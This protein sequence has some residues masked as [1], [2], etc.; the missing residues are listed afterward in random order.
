MVKVDNPQ[1]TKDTKMKFFAGRCYWRLGSSKTSPSY[2]SYVTKSLKDTV[3]KVYNVSASPAQQNSSNVTNSSN[4]STSSPANS[5]TSSPA[6]ASPTTPSPVAMECN[7]SL[8]NLQSP[9]DIN[10][11]EASY[12]ESS[13]L[14]YTYSK[15]DELSLLLIKNTGSVI[16]IEG[17]GLDQDYVTFNGTNYSLKSIE[18]HHG[19]EHRINDVEYPLEA[20]LVHEDAAGNL[21]I[22]AVLFQNGQR[23]ALLE[24]HF[25][26]LDLPK[27]VGNEKSIRPFNLASM[28]GLNNVATEYWS[29]DGTTTSTP[30][31]SAHWLV[32]RH[33]PVISENQIEAFPLKNNS[34]AI[35]ATN[36]R[37]I[38]TNTQ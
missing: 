21:L 3:K 7:T 13:L 30:C 18:F 24:D 2:I 31:T 6:T 5:S 16:K 38:E 11:T 27:Q 4:S 19:S 26:W 32:L 34:R 12:V 17:T 23:N 8:A 14:T 20:Q 9:I 33:K 15:G 22:I 10:S 25:A 35:Q 1:L 28:F 37:S 36:G 29:Y